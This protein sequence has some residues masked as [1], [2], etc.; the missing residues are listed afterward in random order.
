[1][2]KAPFLGAKGSFD[3]PR[4]ATINSEVWAYLE[5]TPVFVTD[6]TTGQQQ[7]APPPQ[8]NSW[9]APIQW[10]V[11]LG[12]WFS[13]HIKAVTAIYDP[14]LGQ[15]KGDQ[16]GKAIEQLRSES[17]V[18]NFSY[19][20]NLHRAIEVMYGQMCEILPKIMD[21]PRAVTIVR[22]DSQHE[23]VQ[24]NRDFGQSGIDEATGE[25]GK[26]N[27][28]AL[29]EYS[30]RVTVGPS[31][32][33]RN[34]EAINQFMEFLKI[35]PA[36][37]QAPGIAGK[38]L[39]WIGQGNP[40]ILAIA[41]QLDPQPQAGGSP[42]QMQQMLQASEQQK[43]QLLQLVQQMYAAIQSKMPE[44]EQRKW[45]DALKALTSIRVAEI[46]ASKD[47]DAANADREAALMETLLGFG[48][49]ADMAAQEQ[50]HQQ[51]MQSEQQQHEAAS[52]VSQQAAQA[53]Q[54]QNSQ[55]EGENENG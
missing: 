27:N 19:A 30:V 28:I 11:V 12:Q 40:Q 9:E 23:I 54:A 5:Y 55:T 6:E 3:D 39:R 20:D 47:M 33:T 45:S 51:Q 8:R 43:Q 14:S 50:A 2:P 48:H 42:Q 44:I 15:Q 18:G 29:G 36:I 26:A 46:N 16:S 17:N 7:L 35:D 37:I 1:M 21:G 41:D 13:D 49:E 32:E 53:E 4:W 25:K 38:A 24:I 34:E 10:L 22:P 52:Q 31:F